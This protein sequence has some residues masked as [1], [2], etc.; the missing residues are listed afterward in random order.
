[1]DHMVHLVPASYYESSK[2]MKSLRNQR[3]TTI[4][5]KFGTERITLTQ[6]YIKKKKKFA[7]VLTI[8]LPNVTSSIFSKYEIIIRRFLG[9][10][11]GLV[12]A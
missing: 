5:M 3:T 7:L 2:R 12:L 10:G 9:Y 1:M 8:S 11:L 6:A 4:E